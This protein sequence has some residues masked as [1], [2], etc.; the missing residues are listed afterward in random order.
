MANID[1]HMDK[2]EQVLIDKMCACFFLT[3]QSYKK[4]SGL[5]KYTEKTIADDF[6]KLKTENLHYSFFL[7]LIA[8]A[9]ADGCIMDSE[10]M[11]L[12]QIAGLLKLGNE[13]FYSLINFSQA[14]SHIDINAGFDPMFEYAINN[15]F[16]WVKENNITLYRETTLAFNSEVDQYLKNRL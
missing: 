8:M 16:Q 1:G 15:F 10:K 2:N 3:K 4:N 11:L 7:D 6:H 14:V 12:A 5:K 13:E 9:L